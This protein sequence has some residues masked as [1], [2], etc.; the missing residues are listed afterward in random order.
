MTHE[1]KTYDEYPTREYGPTLCPGCEHGH[2]VWIGDDRNYTFICSHRCG[3]E[4]PDE[5]R[6][7][8][9]KAKLAADAKKAVK[10]AK[11][12]TVEFQ[13]DSP[14]LVQAIRAECDRRMEILLAERAKFPPTFTKK[15]KL[16][17]K[18]TDKMRAHMHTFAFTGEQI[19][20]ELIN[21]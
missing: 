18:F 3:W 16:N 2:T 17:P 1:G 20:E 6:T 19:R 10:K 9:Y 4:C 5:E 21:S 11:K 13:L 8:A 15:G 14:E 12:K 7:R